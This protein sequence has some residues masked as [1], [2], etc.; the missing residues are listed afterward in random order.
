MVVLW[1]DFDGSGIFGEGKGEGGGFG[2]VVGVV[3]VVEMKEELVV[4]KV[5][6]W[7]PWRFMVEKRKKK[8]M[9]LFGCR[10]WP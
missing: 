3:V 7:V 1:R 6:K 9:G 5:V 4:G 2:G 8:M 10:N